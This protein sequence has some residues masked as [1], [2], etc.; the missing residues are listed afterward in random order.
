MPMNLITEM[1]M[2]L[3][4]KEYKRL[5]S[6]EECQIEAK[7][8]IKELLERTMESALQERLEETRRNYDGRPDRRNGYYERSLLSAFG[9]IE[10]IRVPRGRVTSI[11]DVVL[12]KYRRS[13]PEFD[14]AVVHSF[15]LGHSTRKSKRF[16][17]EFLGEVGVS[18]TQVSRILSRLD[19]HCRKWHKR[20]ITKRYT[21]LWL[22]GKYARIQGARKHPYAVLFAYG[23]TESGDRELLDFQIHASEGT[24][25]WECLLHHLVD[26]GLDRHGLKLVIRDENSGCN[27]AVLTVFGNVPQQS[28]AVHLE[29]NVGKLVSKANRAE[30]QNQVSE[31]FKQNSLRAARAQLSNTLAHWSDIEPEASMYLQNNVDRSLVFYQIARGPWR[32]HLKATNILERFFRELKRFEKSRQFR[33]ADRKSCD[34]FYY[35]FTYDYNDRHQR[36]PHLS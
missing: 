30:F 34:R 31:I 4:S 17:T 16:F 15:L 24:A 18:P 13:Q 3:G 14:A 22:D 5:V 26:R 32:T 21:Y 10:G 2:P 28:C 29:R 1:N 12:P 19:E 20:P 11:A 33:F 6:G 7:K 23:A 35:A 9:Y 36:M 27:D 25:N 8:A